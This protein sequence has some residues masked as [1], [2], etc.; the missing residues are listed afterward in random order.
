M[1]QLTKH[2]SS[3]SRSWVRAYDRGDEERRDEIFRLYL[4]HLPYV[5]DWDLVDGYPQGRG[6]D[7]VTLDGR[8][9]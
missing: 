1:P 7:S 5:N 4:D 8:R 2:G 6:L 3:R 9:R